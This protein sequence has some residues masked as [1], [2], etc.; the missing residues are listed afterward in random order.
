MN[1][2]RTE[3]QSRM[4]VVNIGSVRRFARRWLITRA[5]GRQ[6][7][8]PKNKMTLFLMPVVLDV[9]NT[10][11]VL[12]SMIRGGGGGT[13]SLGVSANG[14]IDDVIGTREEDASLR[15]HPNATVASF[16]YSA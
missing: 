11:W 9:D 10:G 6:N 15:E 1:G 14:G 3:P 8:L 4:Y 16:L 7:L 12:K 13:R 2:S 5:W